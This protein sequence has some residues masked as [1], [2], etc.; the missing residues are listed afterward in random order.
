MIIN[1]DTISNELKNLRFKDRDI[2]KVVHFGQTVIED[3]GKYFQ[4]KPNLIDLC[5]GNGMTSYFFYRKNLISSS[6]L[7]DNNRPHSFDRIGSQFSRE[8]FDFQYGIEDILSDNFSLDGND[9]QNSVLIAVH[10]CGNLSDKVIAL[11]LRYNLPFAVMTCCH[12]VGKERKRYLL[13]SPPDSRLQ[14]YPEVEDY[15][16]YERQRFIEEY[17]RICLKREIP[18]KVSPKNHILISPI[19]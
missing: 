5:A 7:I 15:F 2:Q 13:R 6:V 1:N 3:L 18:K 16:D 19:N 14:L 11:G 10:A 12:K 4:R 9:F 17:G 8:G